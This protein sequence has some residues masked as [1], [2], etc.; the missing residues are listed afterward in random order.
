MGNRRQAMSG[1][2][3]TQLEV[4][5]PNAKT[6]QPR[7]TCPI[8]SVAHGEARTTYCCRASGGSVRWPTVARQQ[9]P[10]RNNHRRRASRAGRRT[11]ASQRHASICKL[12]L[13]FPRRSED[14]T[15]LE[16][17]VRESRSGQAQS[18][19]PFRSQQPFPRVNYRPERDRSGPR[20]ELPACPRNP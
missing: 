6:M 2:A 15:G 18:R 19:R 11:G 16:A 3:K 4:H 5:R 20:G 14:L 13:G 9:N 10:T 8:V 17:S 7:A 1:R 12:L